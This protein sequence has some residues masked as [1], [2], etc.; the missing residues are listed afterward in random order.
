MAKITIGKL[1]EVNFQ[2]Y[3]YLLDFPHWYP[4]INS[5]FT[6]PGLTLSDAISCQVTWN[7]NQFPTL[8][9]TYPR[10]GV[11][12]KNLKENTYIMAD[13][14]SKFVHQLFKIVHVTPEDKQVVVDANHI[15]ST[16]NDA[17]VPDAIQIVSGS[18]QD[19]MNQILNTMQP[20]KDFTFD[21]K[22]TTVSN[23]NIEKGQQAGSLLID[24]DQEGDTAVQ[25]VLGLFGG[26]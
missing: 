11:H 4:S 16:L 26:E 2:E 5:D 24:P 8:Q 7:Y 21:S 22:V 23:I 3:D 13:V 20:A 18:A 10:D 19:L 6:T 17:T 12:V 9:L 1:P 15:A 14:N 25:S